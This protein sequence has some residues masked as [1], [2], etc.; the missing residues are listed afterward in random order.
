MM[1]DEITNAELNCLRSLLRAAEELR[2]PV[3]AVGASARWLVFNLP[4]RIPVHRTTT[5][6]DFG[7]CVPDWN[8][9]R[10][11]CDRLK[12]QSDK[13]GQGRYEH[14][15]IHLSSGTKIDL[16]PFGGIEDD[17]RI[18]W[19]VSAMEMN[20]FGFSDAFEHA[21]RVE[22]AADLNLPVATVPL[23]VALKFFAFADRKNQDDR[24]LSDLWHIVESYPLEGRE[25][26]L[27]E[28]PLS[29]I[30]DEQFDWEY[31]RPLL[32]GFDVGRACQRATVERLLPI[33]E[34]LG[35]PYGGAVYRLI[36]RPPSAEWEEKERRRVS[37]SFIWLMKGLKI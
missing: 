27:V 9:F 33:V 7:V 26:E 29:L 37:T 18:R 24:D 31:A 3:F 15:L 25:C 14:E 23:L 4:N 17:G 20:V 13:F 32:L 21:I 11:L 28:E 34:E 10:Q 35:D 5:D 16:V 2:I 1:N 8:G 22:L 30:V 19:P 36:H 6:W 12:A